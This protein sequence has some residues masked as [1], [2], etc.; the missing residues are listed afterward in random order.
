MAEVEELGVGVLDELDGG[1]GA[2]GGVVEEG[3]VP[4]DNGK[5]VNVVGDAGLK[6]LLTLGFGEAAGVAA[7]DLG[8]VKRVL[9]DQV[10]D[11][12]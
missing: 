12:G 7:D 11:R 8:D 1:L 3:G 2:G 6:N 4:A 9:V 10:G 5:V